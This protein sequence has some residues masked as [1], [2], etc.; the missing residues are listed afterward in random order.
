MPTRPSIRTLQM[1]DTIDRQKRE[2]E[3]IRKQF[4]EFAD[5]RNAMSLALINRGSHVGI[6][7]AD[8]E[9]ARKWQTAMRAARAAWAQTFGET[10]R[11]CY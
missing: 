6:A 1:Q 3:A 11:P 10:G 4:V 9:Q 7:S 5:A 8:D 2:L